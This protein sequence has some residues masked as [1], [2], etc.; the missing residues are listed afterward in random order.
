MGSHGRWGV[1]VGQAVHSLASQMWSDTSQL[2]H[3]KIVGCL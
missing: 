2:V 1:L 3:N